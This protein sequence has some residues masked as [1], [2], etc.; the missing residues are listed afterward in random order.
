MRFTRRSRRF[1]IVVLVL[2]MVLVLGIASTVVAVDAYIH[3]VGGI[4]S[5]AHQGWYTA[6]WVPVDVEGGEN[7][8]GASFDLH[9]SVLAAYAE[10]LSLGAIGTPAAPGATGVVTASSTT[11]PCILW[12]D[13]VDMY[14]YGTDKVTGSQ[15]MFAIGLETEVNLAN[16]NIWCDQYSGRGLYT[17]NQAVVNADRCNI[18]TKGSVDSPAVASSFSQ[19]G[20]INLSS[21]RVETWGGPGSPAFYSTGGFYVSSTQAFSHQSD[22]AWLDGGGYYLWVDKRFYNLV[23][24]NSALYVDKG[25]GVSFAKS[26]NS[27]VSYDG[28]SGLVMQ[29]CYLESGG[30]LFYAPNSNALITLDH[31]DTDSNSGVLLTT[32]YSGSGPGGEQPTKDVV[33][34]SRESKVE[35]N[36][37]ASTL[38]GD[39]ITDVNQYSGK[40]SVVNLTLYGWTELLGAINKANQG[41]VNV[42][43]A[44]EANWEV[45]ADSYVGS[46]TLP[47]VTMTHDW[48]DDLHWL[49]FE[50]DLT[51]IHS[52][53]HLVY[54]DALTSPSLGFGEYRLPEGGWL[55]PAKLPVRA[56]MRPG[57]Q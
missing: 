7:P 14:S 22:G 12:L 27:V 45:A 3:Q 55:L 21:A 31:L 4:T 30:P 20:F 17:Q 1:T 6:D 28:Q 42:T 52:H 24:F 33:P 51:M 36:A 34:G 43:L 47:I 39:I 53:G 44:H 35:L 38:R 5:Y 13:S 11:P 23:M 8:D 48:G 10:N 40:P 57:V 18:T 9:N 37:T 56:G 29:A 50:P 54:Y 25:N 32:K 2:A 49:E 26:P 19:G 41:T 46:L 16:C 15:G